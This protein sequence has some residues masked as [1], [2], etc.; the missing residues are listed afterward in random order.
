MKCG[1]ALSVYGTRIIRF[2]MTTNIQVGAASITSLLIKYH[3]RLGVWLTRGPL[4][5]I[6]PL[7][8]FIGELPVA[9]IIKFHDNMCFQLLKLI[10]MAVEISS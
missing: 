9:L 4:P 7:K 3:T 5:N 2:I 10:S 8:M 1:T 6:S